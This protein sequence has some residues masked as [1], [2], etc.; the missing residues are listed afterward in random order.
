MPFLDYDSAPS[1]SPLPDRY[2]D[3]GKPC[4]YTSRELIRSRAEIAADHVRDLPTA[5]GV[6]LRAPLHL[7]P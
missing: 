1:E 4:A 6:S 2:S 7:D 5:D 3:R